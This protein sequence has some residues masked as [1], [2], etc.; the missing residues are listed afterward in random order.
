MEWDNYK[1]VYRNFEF[2]ISQ[3]MVMTLISHEV[4]KQWPESLPE[5]TKK[6]LADARKQWRDLWTA[7]FDDK[8]TSEQFSA[9]LD[10]VY[11]EWE[12]VEGQP[13][14]FKTVMRMYLFRPDLASSE[15][16][17]NRIVNSQAFAMLFAHLD[18]FMADS[19]R[20][21]CHIR[22]EILKC[23]K[24]IEWVDIISCGT[25]DKLIDRLSEQYSFQ[26]GW[27]SVAKRLDFL[28]N[29]IGLTL[30]FPDEKLKLIED[31]EYIRNVVIH[32]GGN[33]S[34]EYLDRSKRTDVSLGQPIPI[35][36]GSIRQLFSSISLLGDT[37]YK[38]IAKKFYDKDNP[39]WI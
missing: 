4:L 6:P 3:S 32:N 16:D 7:H 11:K 38:A 34:Q 9:E 20:A 39:D 8:I 22:P 29:Q 36:L 28:R 18:A 17:F 21:I 5:N 31:S 23:D 25:W 19:I 1:K 33:A 13:A 10:R 15:L 12:R 26:F 2:S 24:K 35:T 30:I 14:L 37:L 27:Q